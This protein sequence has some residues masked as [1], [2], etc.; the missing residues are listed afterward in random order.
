MSTQTGIT[1]NDKLREFFGKC[2][3]GHSRGKY[4]M[5][6]VIISQEELTLDEAK[7]TKGTWKNDWDELVLSAI[8]DNEPCYLLYRLDEKDGDT[9]KWLMISW[10]PDTASVRNKMLYASTKAT[11]KKEFGGGQIKDDLYGNMKE[12]IT[13]RGYQKHVTSAS[14][15]GPMSRE[16][17]ER[18]E[19]KA[20]TNHEISVDSKHQTMSG[21]SFPMTAA[22]RDAIVNYK[23]QKTNY[24]QLSINIS[25]E[26]IELEDQTSCD[27]KSLPSRVPEG[28]PRYHL[29]RFDHTHEGD[30]LKSTTFIYT[31]PG[32]NCS[33]KDRMLYAS[34]KNAVV[35]VLENDG[36]EIIKKI[37]V[38][39]GSE[40]T[41]E[42]LQDELH[43]KKNVHQT[44]FDRPK[45][46]SRG[47]GPRRITKPVS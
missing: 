6:K 22:V 47:R 32:Y 38:D 3:E 35:E 19:V 5:L 41:E 25:K 20:Q 39:S 43:P 1:A 4:R 23:N 7:E 45:P 40:L 29:F 30:Y 17:L 26:I 13:F 44:K 18:E 33:I 9:F 10:S 8:D 27:S 37:E 12:D 11:L 46:P 15:P 14:A 2:R 31:M 34:S 24:V 21:L 28:A 36:I 16:E 42:F